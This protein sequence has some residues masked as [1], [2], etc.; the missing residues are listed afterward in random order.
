M[1]RT[2]YWNDGGYVG[3]VGPY[4]ISVA[5]DKNRKLGGW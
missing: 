4:K 3:T 2:A 5:V 1:L